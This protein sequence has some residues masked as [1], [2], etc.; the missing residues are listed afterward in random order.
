[1]RRW[2]RGATGILLA[3]LLGYSLPASRRKTPA[4]AAKF[5]Y[6][7]LSLSW[8]PAFCATP[9]GGDTRE[10]ASGRQLGFVV[11]GLWP[12]GNSGRG[13]ENCQ[14]SQPVAQSVMALTLNYIP[15][16]SLIQHEWA[17]HGTCS[18]LNQADYFAAMRRAR[19]SVVMPDV[20]KGPPKVLVLSPASIEEQFAAANPSFPRNAFRTACTAGRLSEVRVCFAKDL[21]P[22]ACTSATGSCSTKVMEVLPVR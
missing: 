4:A 13:P 9:G 7:L 14:A 8:A 20:F 11:H 6:Y 3:L 12:Q 21:S 19:D 15:T 16:E 18:G 10:C 22:Q 1:M 2:G 5:D 17:T